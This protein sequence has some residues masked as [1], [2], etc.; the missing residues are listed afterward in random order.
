MPA[1]PLPSRCAWGGGERERD[2]K[3]EEGYWMLVFALLDVIFHWH[4]E[5]SHVLDLYL[6][7]YILL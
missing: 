6:L 5:V 2:V 1:R 4:L 7:V 3:R